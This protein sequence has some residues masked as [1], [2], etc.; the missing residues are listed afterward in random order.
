[1]RHRPLSIARPCACGLSKFEEPSLPAKHESKICHH[2]GQ[3]NLEN[4]KVPNRTRNP[5]KLRPL[6]QN[7]LR[8]ANSCGNLYKPKI[9]AP[10]AS[11]P[12]KKYA[13]TKPLN[14][15]FMSFV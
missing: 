1:M 11:H 12:N 6:R 7:R 9:T 15:S 4:R 3:T 5:N 2:C 8:S 13:P 10:S 14:F